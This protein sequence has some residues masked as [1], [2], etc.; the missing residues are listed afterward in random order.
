MLARRHTQDRKADR[1]AAMRKRGRAY[2]YI[3]EWMDEKGLSDEEVGTKLGVSRTTVWRW[4]KEQWRLDPQKMANLA[5]AIGIKSQD[6]FKAP[7]R[8]SID[9]VLEGAPQEVYEATMELA[10][11]LAR[12]RHRP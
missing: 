1:L 3:V 12:H 11:R 2:L 7:G 6:L 8:E 10:R 4:R 9:A 5:D